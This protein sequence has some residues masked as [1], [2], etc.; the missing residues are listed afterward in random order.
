MICF[1]SLQFVPLKSLNSRSRNILERAKTNFSAKKKNSLMKLN[2]KSFFNIDNKKKLGFNFKNVFYI[3][4]A[5]LTAIFGVF[6]FSSVRSGED[7][8]IHPVSSHSFSK[9]PVMTKIKTIPVFSVT[10]RFGQPFL[11]QNNEGEHVGLIFFSHSE[12]LEF[13][14]ELE[15]SHQATNPRIFIMGLDKAV[16]MVGQGATSSGIKDRFGQDIKMR[17]QFIPEQKQVDYSVSLNKTA[18]DS[19]KHSNVPIFTV[20][21][22]N[23]I[24]GKERISPMFLSKE[25]LDLAWKNLRKNN[26]DLD[27]RPIIIEGDLIQLIFYMKNNGNTLNS[28]LNIG[29]VPSNESLSFVK[30]EIK[31]EPSAKMMF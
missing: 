13:G 25:D 27:R 16:K 31:A 11:I 12:A 19:R 26:P 22:L 2:K 30:K 1:N 28:L 3:L 29:F 10:N 7:G 23:I 18:A 20:P 8:L 5:G 15:K 14:R 4:V 17:F 24:K 9:K 6:F 21:G